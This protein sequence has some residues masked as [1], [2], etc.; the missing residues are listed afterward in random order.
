MMATSTAGYAAARHLR[1]NA[2]SRVFTLLVDATS[3]PRGL[4][5]I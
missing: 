3:K 2:S 4:R 1:H 5:E